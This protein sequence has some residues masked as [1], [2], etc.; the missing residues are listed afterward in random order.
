L[1]ALRKRQ[2]DVGAR[3]AQS[4]AQAEWLYEQA[5]RRYEL[6]VFAWR[7]A[8]RLPILVLAGWRW[9]GSRR[10]RAWRW[11]CGGGRVAL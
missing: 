9:V 7:L 11:V 4:R 5:R 8:F 2:E 3:L 1:D 6:V 10:V